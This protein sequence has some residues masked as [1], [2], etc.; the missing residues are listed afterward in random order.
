MRLNKLFN[1]TSND[2]LREYLDKL[3]SVPQT[4]LLT[5]DINEDIVDKAIKVGE[6]GN[7]FWVKQLMNGLK[8][9][10]VH[11]LN[12]IPEEDRPITVGEMKKIVGLLLDMVKSNA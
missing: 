1:Q 4:K 3:K 6:F 7:P 5:E 12:V 8:Q 10:G 2:V 11:G 9:V